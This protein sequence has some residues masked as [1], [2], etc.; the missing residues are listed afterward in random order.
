M[1]NGDPNGVE[2]NEWGQWTQ[3][4]TPVAGHW[5]MNGTMY[6]NLHEME[7]HQI[8]TLVEAAH[9]MEWRQISTL[10]EAAHDEYECRAA[11]SSF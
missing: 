11:P 7:W 4:A 2:D 10:V 6:E 3:V 5:K 1:T 9:K 8:Y